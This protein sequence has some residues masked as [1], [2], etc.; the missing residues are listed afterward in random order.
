MNGRDE[1]RRGSVGTGGKGVV[2]SVG[3]DREGVVG[4][5]GSDGK[6]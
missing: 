3:T 4:S 1:R 6:G 5:V 2:G